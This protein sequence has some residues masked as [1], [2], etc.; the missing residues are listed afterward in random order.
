MYVKSGVLAC[1]R[2]GQLWI[3]LSSL[4]MVDQSMC[5]RD[6]VT[7]EV[8][9][10]TVPEEEP[11][12]PL[13]PKKKLKYRSQ[14]R[15]MTW[16]PEALSRWR[17]LEGTPST[18]EVGESSHPPPPLPLTEEP[19][20]VT[21][22]T[23]IARTNTHDHQIDRVMEDV[24]ELEKDVENTQGEMVDVRSQM[25]LDGLTVTALRDR[26]ATLEDRAIASEMLARISIVI[27][28]FAM[29]FGMYS[30]FSH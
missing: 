17:R 11:S 21:I 12:A 8:I 4:N 14:A 22:P 9:T 5:Y 24:K 13:P 26:V 6:P 2:R 16:M 1:H 20:E 19:M 18:Y 10:P 29:I 28:G 15:R 7:S 30:H 23:L 27:A 25:V 3:T